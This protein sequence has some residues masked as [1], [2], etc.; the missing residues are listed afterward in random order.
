MHLLASHKPTRT[1]AM[2]LILLGSLVSSIHGSTSTDAREGPAIIYIDSLYT[3]QTLEFFRAS[4]C[5]LA[6]STRPNQSSL[7]KAQISAKICLDRYTLDTVPEN[8]VP[9]LEF[10]FLTILCEQDSEHLENLENLENTNPN[11]NQAP[12]KTPTSKELVVKVFRALS[13][14]RANV[15]VFDGLRIDSTT[16]G[17]SGSKKAGNALDIFR[18]AKEPSPIPLHIKHLKIENMSNIS[19]VFLLSCFDMQNCKFSI[20]FDNIP[21]ICKPHTSTNLG[22]TS[23]LNVDTVG[24]S[25]DTALLTKE[26]I[27]LKCLHIYGTDQTLDPLSETLKPTASKHWGKLV[28]PVEAWEPIVNRIEESF[29]KENLPTSSVHLEDFDVVRSVTYQ[30][31]VTMKQLTVTFRVR[32]TQ[33]KTRT[34]NLND[35]VLLFRKHFGDIESVRLNLYVYTLELVHDFPTAYTEVGHPKLSDIIWARYFGAICLYSSRN[36]LWIAPNAYSDWA[37]GKLNDEMKKVSASQ[38]LFIYGPTRTPF[39]PNMH[40]TNNPKCFECYQSVDDFNGTPAD[41]DAPMYLGIV[42]NSGHMACI[43]CL[44][45]LAK[46]KREMEEP[47]CCPICDAVINNFEGCGVIERDE[48]GLVG[49]KIKPHILPREMEHIDSNPNW[50]EDYAEALSIGELGVL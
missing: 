15:L 3:D 13:N 18:R 40:T 43:T 5:E 23:Y 50:F 22:T 17:N 33:L 21:G 49:F 9:G 41:E 12:I 39:L 28:V 6:A 44:K 11:T 29:S 1:L 10:D 35:T 4:G 36:I 2:A 46:K 24:H 31:R 38:I 26:C 32:D 47:L 37:S 16:T 27:T 45:K 14:F 42:C 34:S 48:K 7:A 20:W 30:E 8:L 19:T 25:K